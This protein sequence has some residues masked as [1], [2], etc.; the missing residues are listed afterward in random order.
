MLVQSAKC[1]KNSRRRGGGNTISKP[2]VTSRPLA[3]VLI[4]HVPAERV[5]VP[6]RVPIGETKRHMLGVDGHDTRFLFFDTL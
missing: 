2:I 5:D 6:N 4:V 1:K 3:F